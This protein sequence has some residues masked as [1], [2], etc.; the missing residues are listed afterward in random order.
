MNGMG[1]TRESGKRKERKDKGMV[2]CGSRKSERGK[3]QIVTERKQVR[4]LMK[5]E[6]C[7][8]F[9]KQEEVNEKYEMSGRFFPACLDFSGR[10]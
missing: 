6:S 9:V 10:K 1:G 4:V 2:S 3:M 5:S 8:I 7:R